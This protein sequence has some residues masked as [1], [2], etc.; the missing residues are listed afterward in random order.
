MDIEILKNSIWRQIG[1]SIDMLQN[2]IAAFPEDLWGD[3][4][5]QPECW[6]VVFHTLFWLDYYSS[7]TNEGFAPPEPFTLDEMDPAGLLPERVYTKDELLSYL[8]YG[9]NKCRV[10][11]ESLT[12]PKAAQ[13]SSPVRPD[14]GVVELFLY[15][16]RHVQHAA[17][18]LNVVL[19]QQ[20][21]SAPRWVRK[22]D[23]NGGLK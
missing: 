11:I 22:A 18:Q 15:N 12:E 17:A 5:R 7:D 14:V 8:E 21:E 6:Y 9:R 10:A 4:S 23:P 3:R 16:M 19:R 2:S 1:A 20:T 13:V